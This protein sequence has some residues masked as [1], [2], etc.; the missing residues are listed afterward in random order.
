MNQDPA[1]MTHLDAEG[2]A[3][4]VDTS[5]KPHTSR[6]ARARGSVRMSAEALRQVAAGTLEKGDVLTVARLAGIQAAKQTAHL[7]PLCHVLPLDH[8]Q[9]DARVDAERGCVFLEAEVACRA[10]TGAEMEAIVGVLIAAATVYD[11]CK[12]VDRGITIGDVELV[13]KSGGLSGR[14]IRPD[15]A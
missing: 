15:S 11:M 12:A 3:R 5:A 14:W 7:I 4:M 10:A 6:K 2:R 8:V 13:E 9:V 1:K